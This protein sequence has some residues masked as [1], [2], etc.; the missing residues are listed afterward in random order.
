MVEINPWYGWWAI[1]IASVLLTVIGMAIVY[2]R[3]EQ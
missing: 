3:W 2:R 1:V